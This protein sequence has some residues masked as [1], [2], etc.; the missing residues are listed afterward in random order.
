MKRA[1]LWSDPD[2]QLALDWRASKS[3]TAEWA[4]QYG[5][6]DHDQAMAFLDESEAHFGRRRRVQRRRQIISTVAGAVFLFVVGLLFYAL[7]RKAGPRRRQP[8]P[9]RRKEEP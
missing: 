6:G 8:W 5:G 4:K 9:R 7:S 3:P 1:S 2:L